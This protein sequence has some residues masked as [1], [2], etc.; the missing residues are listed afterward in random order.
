M[1][2]LAGA[3]RLRACFAYV[4]G[5]ALAVGLLAGPWFALLMREFGN[6]AFPLLN[7]WFRSPHALPINLI[8]D[9][10]PFR[11]PISPLPF[12]FPLLV[13]RPHIYFDNIS[14]DPRLGAPSVSRPGPPALPPH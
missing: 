9:R 10:I 6:P 4:L 5:A 1:P 11:N 2:G 7:A 3:S 12:P 13:L 14:P 8:G